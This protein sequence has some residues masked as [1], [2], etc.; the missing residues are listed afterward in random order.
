M[1][2]QGGFVSKLD[3]AGKEIFR[4]ANFGSFPAGTAVD[5]NGDI[6]WIGTGGAPGFPPLPI[7][8]TIFPVS[9][10]DARTAGFVIKF[11][12]SDGSIIWA[13]EVDALKPQAIAL[14]R[15][16]ESR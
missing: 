16:V 10:I 3:S 5:A 14:V 9:Q 13:A 11:R 12:G 6:Y 2:V 1:N 7:T 4:F 15:T 8:K